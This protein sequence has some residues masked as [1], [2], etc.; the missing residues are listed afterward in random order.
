MSF[1]ILRKIILLW[2]LCSPKSIISVTLWGF[3]LK[4]SM[5]TKFCRLDKINWWGR[6]KCFAG[7][8][9]FSQSYKETAFFLFKQT[10]RVIDLLFLTISCGSKS[11][12]KA[13]LFWHRFCDV[14][15]LNIMIVLLYVVIQKSFVSSMIF[16]Y[17]KW[18]IFIRLSFWTQSP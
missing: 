17:R 11:C 18:V 13:M 6:H 15:S 16:W 1:T 8:W 4:Y 12:F 9:M 10:L 3:A 14:G 2:K 5:F 7:S